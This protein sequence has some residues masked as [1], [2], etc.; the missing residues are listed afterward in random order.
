MNEQPDNTQAGTSPD[1][2]TTTDDVD[3]T[4]KPKAVPR[5]TTYDVG[6]EA[7]EALRRYETQQQDIATQRQTEA[8]EGQ[9]ISGENVM[10]R[11]EVQGGGTP[12]LLP[13]TGETV[14]GRRDPSTHTSPELD[15]TPYGAYQMG[16]SRRHAIIRMED[17]KP[18]LTDLG[19]RNGTYINGKKLKAHQT[20]P[21]KDGDEV[22]LGKIVL[23]I[24]FQTEE[25]DDNAV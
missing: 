12:L 10:L 22:R 13:L 3:N 6:D 9:I 4:D 5:S 16:I 7:R 1:N 11:V 19:S 25:D 20:I 15:L 18:M 14:I 21:L 24:T 23:H 8:Q 17:D 2:Q